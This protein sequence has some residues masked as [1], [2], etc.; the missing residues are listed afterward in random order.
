MKKIWRKL[1]AGFAAAVMATSTLSPLANAQSGGAQLV[2]F[3]DSYTANPSQITKLMREFDIPESQMSSD[4]NLVR[5][6]HVGSSGCVQDG[7][8]WP[9][10]LARETGRS[11]ADYSCNARTSKTGGIDDV[12]RAIRAGKLGPNTQ[13][14]ALMLGGNDMGPFGVK[15]TGQLSSEPMLKS[16]YSQRMDRMV[17]RIRQVAP[18][19]QITFASYPAIVANDDRICL[20]NVIPNAPLGIPIPGAKAIEREFSNAIRSTAQR[21]GARFVDV[22]A[23]TA[24]HDTCAPDSQRY[25]AGMLDTTAPAHQMALHPT[26]PGSYAIAR[27]LK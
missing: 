13:E 12:N 19:A 26:V 17:S 11:L 16:N 14:V 5:S 3:G 22:R 2:T 20:L 10:I 1:A 21:N 15:D 24:G 9:R 7:E 23:S 27:A 25:V 6:V 18:N 4:M 8:N